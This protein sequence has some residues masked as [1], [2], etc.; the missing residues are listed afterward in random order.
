MTCDNWNQTA[1]GL[2]NY[3]RQFRS[4][5]ER[6]AVSI[7]VERDPNAHA[8]KDD[9]MLISVFG[10]DHAYED[11]AQREIE[12]VRQ[13]LEEI[14]LQELAFGLSA[15][16]FTW[17]MVIGE[18]DNNLR[19]AAGRIFRREMLK[20]F[21]ED[22]VWNVWKMVTNRTETEPRNSRRVHRDP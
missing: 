1:A 10:N 17:A 18:K 14:G 16:G 9:P 15:D 7:Q 5:V 6:G 3:L 8:R 12:L 4:V 13:A 2:A 20:Y 11:L 19:T 22:L 21:L